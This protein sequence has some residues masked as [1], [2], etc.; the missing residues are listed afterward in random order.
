MTEH[1]VF[2]L[3]HRA[4][5][6]VLDFEACSVHEALHALRWDPLRVTI[7]GWR[8]PTC[9]GSGVNPSNMNYCYCPHGDLLYLQEHEGVPNHVTARRENPA[10]KMVEQLLDSRGG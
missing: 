5:N 10:L 9:N 7:L 1:L 8:C 3:H 4:R 2:R 6:K